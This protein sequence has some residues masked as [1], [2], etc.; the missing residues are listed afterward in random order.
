MKNL[1]SHFQC[2]VSYN[3]PCNT[4]KYIRSLD[5]YRKEVFFG[6]LYVPMAQISREIAPF[7]CVQGK[8]RADH[9]TLSLRNRYSKVEY[10]VNR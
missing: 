2:H 4:E 1:K 9:P 10:I 3:S 7:K 6:V 5:R 8:R